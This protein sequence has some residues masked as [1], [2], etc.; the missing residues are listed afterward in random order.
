[1]PLTKRPKPPQQQPRLHSLLPAF[2]TLAV[3]ILV[4][5]LFYFADS[6]PP[7][8]HMRT[9][10]VLAWVAVFIFL[11]TVFVEYPIPRTKQKRIV[12]IMIGLAAL[13]ILLIPE[14]IDMVAR[15]S[16]KSQAQAYVKFFAKQPVSQRV[17][18]YERYGGE[19][20]TSNKEPILFTNNLSFLRAPYTE[21]RQYRFTPT[22]QNTNPG[23]TLIA[24]VQVFINFP[25]GVIVKQPIM[26]V[27]SDTSNGT[28]V[29]GTIPGGI[30]PD[31]SNTLNESLFLTFSK[32]DRYEVSYTIHGTTAT[33]E[34][35][36]TQRRTFFF[37]L[38]E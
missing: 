7:T 38:T 6:L 26:W 11:W 8:L 33:G 19:W 15:K 25:P 12:F 35:F 14:I 4:A 18:L 20:H 24:P 29:S 1:M 31:M 17:L 28:Q 10:I 27:I 37:H 30:P 32:P 21:G 13:T 2:R 3:T 23:V 22:V 16:V 36:S 34:G 9:A 5:A